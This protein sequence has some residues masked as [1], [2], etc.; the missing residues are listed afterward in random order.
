ML[1]VPMVVA[2]L[3]DEMLLAQLSHRTHDI[4]R[5]VVTGDARSGAQVESVHGKTTSMEDGGL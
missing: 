5:L 3:A 2:R 1:L 4:V